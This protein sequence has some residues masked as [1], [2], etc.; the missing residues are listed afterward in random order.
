MKRVVHDDR[1][2]GVAGFSEYTWLSDICSDG[3][4][5]TLKSPSPQINVHFG[6]KKVSVLAEEEALPSPDECL[7]TWKGLPRRV[8]IHLPAISEYGVALTAPSVGA[9][10]GV[11]G[12]NIVTR[13]RC[14]LSRPTKIAT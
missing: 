3:Q 6:N 5:L 10:S 7:I 1:G 8:G 11:N 9:P 4:K 12:N 2:A 13:R 14:Q